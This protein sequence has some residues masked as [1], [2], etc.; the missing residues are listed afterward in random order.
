MPK[1]GDTMQEGTIARWYKAVGDEIQEGE[2]IAEI[3]TEK[4]SIEIEAFD[5]GPLTKIAVIGAEDEAEAGQAAQPSP[6]A[7]QA[8][9]AA[10]SI[11]TP[12]APETPRIPQSETPPSAQSAPPV[13][14]PAGRTVASPLARRLARENRVDLHDVRGTG[15]GGRCLLYTSRCV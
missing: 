6:P 9:P 13:S 11:S 2:V 14:A 4:A 5:S 3:E 10:H 8:Q 15:P 7:D 12:N 1:M